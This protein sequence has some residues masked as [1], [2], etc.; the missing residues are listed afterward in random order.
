MVNSPGYTTSRL[1]RYAHHSIS[2]G[3]DYNV[4]PS[5]VDESQWGPPSGSEAWKPRKLIFFSTCSA[6]PTPP[7]AVHL[8]LRPALSLTPRVGGFIPNPQ[9]EHTSS[10]LY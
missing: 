6:K 3:T 1:L 2:P 9:T 4:E 5:Q 10:C 7:Y 8:I